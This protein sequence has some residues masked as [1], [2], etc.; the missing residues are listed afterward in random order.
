[1]GI[2]VDI[3][4]I[5]IVVLSAF[6]GYKK[7]LIELGTRVIA[8][9]LAFVVALIL[10]KP[11]GNLIIN[12]TGIDEKIQSTIEEKSS[13][14]INENTQSNGIVNEVGNQIVSNQSRG[15]TLSIIYSVTATILFLLAKILLGIVVALL[16]FVARLPILK[17]FNKVGGI[18]YG[19]VRGALISCICAVV[20]GI[21]AQFNP[22]STVNKTLENT[23]LAKFICENIVKF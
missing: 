2:I 10:F 18:L 20:I 19:V 23:Y 3:V 6:L 7:G 15:V 14:F 1:M 8:G 22:Q 21:I 11:V 17:Q 5:A 13:G 12:Y 4:L 9:I 16:D